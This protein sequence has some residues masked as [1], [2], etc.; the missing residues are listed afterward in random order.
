MPI[1]RQ[2]CEDQSLG[3]AT[4]ATCLSTAPAGVRDSRD[5]L[6]VVGFA[7]GPDDLEL[8]VIQPGSGVAR[9]LGRSESLI[10]GPPGSRSVRSPGA[11]VPPSQTK[12]ARRNRRPD[13]LSRNGAARTKCAP[14]VQTAGHTF[15]IHIAGGGR[16]S[17]PHTRCASS[18]VPVLV[19]A[20][21][22][23]RAR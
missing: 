22:P 6:E 21:I 16:Y 9:E 10:M 3:V 15:T 7:G 23:H 1:S 8:A 14:A 5:A 13:H 18:K 12:R 19:V 11:S 4:C 2:A 17:Q 20:G